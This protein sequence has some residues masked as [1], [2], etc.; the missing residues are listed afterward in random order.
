MLKPLF[1]VS[2]VVA[3]DGFVIPWCCTVL[4]QV[5]DT[6]ALGRCRWVSLLYLGVVQAQVSDITALRES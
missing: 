2:E 3:V 5:S 6:T 4:A 1:S